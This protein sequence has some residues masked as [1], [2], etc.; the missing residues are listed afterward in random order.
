MTEWLPP[1][2]YQTFEV[3]GEDL[4]RNLL[5]YYSWKRPYQANWNLMWLLLRTARGLNM[6][7]FIG[8]FTDILGP[9]RAGQHIKV[10]LVFI[11][12]YIDSPIKRQLC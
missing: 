4:I 11:N 1:F 8:H 10:V 6:A 5:G 9:A 3:A 2:G 12:H 7:F